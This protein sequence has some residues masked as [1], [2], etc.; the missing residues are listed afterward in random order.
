MLLHPTLY[1][2]NKLICSDNC[3]S[4]KRSNVLIV[5]LSQDMRSTLKLLSM[6]TFNKECGSI[7]QQYSTL[8]AFKFSVIY[9]DDIVIDGSTGTEPWLL[10][11]LHCSVVTSVPSSLSWT[12]STHANEKQGRERSVQVRIKIMKSFLKAE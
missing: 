3:Q 11:C 10:Y 9:D 8:F 12:F 1:T 6:I 2:E 5:V 4:C 7:L